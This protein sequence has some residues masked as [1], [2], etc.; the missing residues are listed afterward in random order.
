MSTENIQQS[1]L[2]AMQ[3]LSSSAAGSTNASITI[4]GSIVELLDES[5]HLY[6]VSYGG[7]IYK[8]VY[9]M[10]NV[11]Y[12]PSTVVYVLIP[13]KDDFSQP[14]FI[15]GAVSPTASMYITE[16]EE[17]RYISINSNLFEGDN[18]GNIEL[19]SP[20][21]ITED[22][23]VF[24]GDRKNAFKDYL[25]TYN[26]FLFSAYIK[27]NI[28]KEHQ[29]IG[30][31]GLKLV[32]PFVQK[33][34]G[35]PIT[36]EYKMDVSTIPG[37][38]YALTE[39]QKVDLYFEVEDTIE[40]DTSRN[41]ILY[42]FVKGFEY[43][44]IPEDKSLIPVDIWIKDIN[45]QMVDVLTPENISGYYA[46]ISATEGN[47]FTASSYIN[48]KI[49]TPL[50]KIN[51]KESKLSG[52]DCYWFVEDSSITTTSEDYYSLGGLG[53]KCL[54]EKTNIEMNSEGRKIFQYV[55]NDYKL[56]VSPNDVIAILRY[57]CV[58]VKGDIV[59]QGYIT[60]KNLSIEIE[61]QLVSAIGSNTF[62][63]DIGTVRLIA[64]IFYDGVTNNRSQDNIILST[65]WQR[66][67]KNNNYIDNDFYTIVR[68]NDVVEINGKEYFET[69][70]TY[71][72]RLIDKQ[73]TIYCTFYKTEISENHIEEDENPIQ[74]SNQYNLGTEHIVINTTKEYTY[75]ISLSGGDVLYKYDSDGNSPL[76]SNY[77]GH[78]SSKI[79]TIMPIEFKVYKPDG[80]ELT[81]DE[82]PY[83]KYTWSFP[84]NSM[85]QLI[86]YTDE[87][88]EKLEQDDDYY[89]INGTGLEKSNINYS[90]ARIYNKKKSNN[91]ILLSIIFDNVSIGA[92]ANIKFLKDGESGT[93]GTKYSAIIQYKANKD[94]YYGYGERDA[95]GRVRK[96]QAVFYDSE[97][98]PKQWYKYNLDEDKLDDFIDTEYTPARYPEFKV[99][100][101]KDGEL[102]TEGLSY[103]WSLFESSYNDSFDI[104]Q[105]TLS[106]DIATLNINYQED[107]QTPFWNEDGQIIQCAIQ[108]DNIDDE[109]STNKETIYAYYPLEVTKVRTKEGLIPHLDGGYEE[110]IYASDG[111]NPQ[112]D[113]SNAFYCTDSIYNND[114][115]SNYLTYNWNASTNFTISSI[116][117][118]S[119]KISPKTSFQNGES[120]N[121]VKVTIGIE[122]EQYAEAG[123]N[124]QDTETAISENNTKLDYYNY[125][126]GDNDTEIRKQS[127]LYNLKNFIHETYTI[128][129][130]Q[131]PKLDTILNLLILRQK[132]LEDINELKQIVFNFY[133]YC[134]D[135]SVDASIYDYNT[136]QNNLVEKLS[137]AY[138]NLYL[139]G[140]SSSIED[141]SNNCSLSNIKIDVPENEQ[142]SDS[143]IHQIQ[144]YANDWAALCQEYQKNYIEITFKISDENQYK[145]QGEY[146]ILIEIIEKLFTIHIPSRLINEDN[147][148]F[149]QF[150]KLNIEIEAILNN[151][152][153][154]F[155]TL[156]FIGELSSGTLLGYSNY[157][158]DLLD[159]LRNLLYNY[160]DEERLKLFYDT[161]IEEINQQQEELNKNLIA[162]NHYIEVRENLIIHVKPVIFLYNRYEFAN[163]NGWDGNKLYI[164][165]TNESYLLAPQI[166]AGVKNADNSFTG[167]LMGIK[168]LK[169]TSGVTKDIGLLG[170][171]DGH[172]TIFLDA[173]TGKAEFGAGGEGQIILQPGDKAIIK[174]GNYNSLDTPRY[175]EVYWPSGNPKDNKYYIKSNNEYKEA[176]ETTVQPNTTYYVKAEKSGMMIDLTTP[177][178][179][180][181][182][183]NF[184]VSPEGYITAVGGG[185]I[186]G[187][188]INNSQIYSKQSEG[189]ITIDCG[190][191]KVNSSGE[192]YTAYGIYSHNHD[193][194]DKIN[195]GFYLS[196]E[197]LSI[198]N[199]IRIT[200]S[201][202]VTD[203]DDSDPSKGGLIEIGRLSGTKKWTISGDA[204][205]SYIS[206]GTSGTNNS[207]YISTNKITLGSKVYIDDEGLVRLG[208]HA[209]SDE[210]EES[211]NKKYWT[212]NGEENGES[213]ISYNTTKFNTDSTS[214]Y[215][216]TDGISL[217]KNKFYVDNTGILTAK[218]GFIGGW[219]FNSTSIFKDNIYIN[220]GGSIKHQNENESNW[221]IEKNGYAYFKNVFLSGVNDGSSFGQMNLTDGSNF[222]GSA[223]SAP[224]QTGCLTHIDSLI[225]NKVTANFVEALHISAESLTFQGKDVDW[226]E[227]TYVTSI[228]V[229]SSDKN[230]VDVLIP[231]STAT[232]VDT[233]GNTVT[234]P[235]STGKTTITY[236][237]KIKISYNTKKSHVLGSA[238]G[239]SGSS[240]ATIIE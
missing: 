219:E 58:L 105:D 173:K 74:V 44:S 81:E 56:E 104:V 130:E 201:S 180:F 240:S 207:V 8:D 164:D 126:N 103:V 6:S 36:R 225:V 49:L 85:M 38:P 115:Q 210:D 53:W 30:N 69:E 47:Y 78:L 65:L 55:I 18:I 209:V 122:D 138:K 20:I 184:K 23:I 1:F 141:I 187:W 192:K 40:Y 27:T 10:S 99:V 121:V 117:G 157:V 166:G 33:I 145:Y 168:H 45:F 193:E 195:Q 205:N 203:G 170:L 21:D 34:D 183:G 118:A 14:K 158:E 107:N 26:H 77:D 204:D 37:N 169:N 15:L 188:K 171:K 11:V 129:D 229:D 22:I 82:Y 232:V 3:L 5:T 12:T 150:N 228:S 80:M 29:Q 4:K 223:S 236:H 136:I 132:M 96:F 24:N 231:G 208:R 197:G 181:G 19:K 43:Y 217:G 239:S 93:N 84:K 134:C 52:W 88:L 214:V 125:H 60:L 2:E 64:R 31:Y 102:Y 148:E 61:T 110:V 66:F 213:Y 75:T 226:K 9:S 73:N 86:G 230:S 119:A 17:D 124:K 140:V 185:T 112:F 139:L 190:T 146:D 227:I 234:V 50:L 216:G 128:L 79:N 123:K 206:Y 62:I 83:V 142:I 191:E 109:S 70:I 63:E 218:K 178:I 224:F 176:T 76:I 120:K 199:T 16:A 167:L 97:S 135:R 72:C 189:R 159:K 155:T 68:E 13:N 151:L 39:F 108:I 42:Y 90:I 71:P 174:S 238:D 153:N 162:Y 67:D 91:T 94:N 160:N 198:G 54:N 116:D 186:A 147:P 46:T 41:A 163:L 211:I 182:S 237:K 220:S 172:Q 100:V 25:N 221:G 161:K 149:E 233:S 106:Q 127:N 35:L 202:G 87:E 48:S 89:Y 179:E 28:D 152:K 177:K 111:T 131:R 137:R 154:Y 133:N 200:A 95:K 212:I 51:G 165:K 59:V 101:Y 156:L 194:L 32:L 92:S 98:E 175:D 57:K 113:N 144:I 215:I 222:Y 143:V 235:T 196:K 7:A 114:E